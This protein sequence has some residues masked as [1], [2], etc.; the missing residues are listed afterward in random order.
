MDKGEA[1]VS[2]DL[3]FG[4]TKAIPEGATYIS[5]GWYIKS[6]KE[7]SAKDDSVEASNNVLNNDGT[8]TSNLV[9]IDVPKNCY[10]LDFAEKAFVKYV[11]VDGT[12][13]EAIESQYQSRSVSA[14]ADAIL[15]HPMA[16]QH[17]KQYANEIKSAIQ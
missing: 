2:T 14:V 4:Y 10:K 8:V 9:L 5:N 3:R 16:S 6:L 12:A 1:A 17:E 15:R 13:V 11:T 7:G